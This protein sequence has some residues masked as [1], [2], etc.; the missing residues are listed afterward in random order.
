MVDMDYGQMPEVGQIAI[1]VK[2]RDEAVQCY[3]KMFN[4]GP[5]VSLEYCPERAVMSASG[6]QNA[7]ALI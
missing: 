5:F 3:S 1:V 4:I 7:A 2:N 6:F